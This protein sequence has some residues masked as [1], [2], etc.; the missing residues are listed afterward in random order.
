MKSP[1]R[2]PAGS[3]SPQS[4]QAVPVGLDG[5]GGVPPLGSI[6][7]PCLLQ[8]LFR[9]S[10]GSADRPG[11]RRPPAHSIHPS[12]IHLHRL[13]EPLPAASAGAEPASSSAD[14]RSPA[15]KARPI[16]R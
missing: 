12:I 6:P 11:A 13:A 15:E 14:A 10:A 9:E 4:W 5:R 8:V 1:Q 16:F 3:G 2:L 7:G